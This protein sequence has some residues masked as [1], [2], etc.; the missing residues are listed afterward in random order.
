MPVVV[1]TSAGT[2]GAVLLDIL[3]VLVAAKLAAELA[4]RIKVPAVVAEIVAGVIVGP[5]VL[6]LVGQGN[7]TLAVLAEIGVILLLLEVGLEMNVREMASVGR[8]AVSV[9]VIGIVIPMA[10]GYGVAIAFGESGNTALFLGAALAATSVGIT[11]RVFSD[12]K[13]LSTVEA[14]TVLG[15]AVVDDVLG[16]VVLTVV[17]GIVTKGSISALDVLGIVGIA[18]GFLV[19]TTSLGLAFAPRLFQAIQRFAR[20]PGTL[21]ALTLSFTLAL[22]ELASAAQLAPIIGAFVAGLALSQSKVSDRI[23]RDVAPIGHIFIPVFFLQIGIAINISA[24][25]KPSVLAIAGALIVVAVLG[26]VAASIGLLGAPG[27]K[28]LVGLGMIP[29]GEVGLIFA[30]IGLAEGIL[31]ND[32]YG[33]LLLVVLGTTLLTPPLLKSRYLRVRA[34][35]KAAVVAPSPPPS[36]GWLQIRHNAVELAAEP[37][38]RLALWLALDAAAMV[39]DRQAGPKLL[40]WLGRASDDGFRWDRATVGAFM[41]LLNVGNAR[42]WRF[43]ESTGVLERALPELSAA[44][45]R[46]QSDPFMLDPSQVLEYELVDRLR[47]LTPDDATAAM[48]MDELM[49]PDRLMLAALMLDTAGTDEPVVMARQVVKRLDLGAGAEEEIALLVGQPS[50]MRA[51]AARIDGLDEDQVFRLAGA[52]D[53]PERTNALYLL[54]VVVG[55]LDPL[56]RARLDELRERVLTVLDRPE[57]TGLDARNLVE[58]RKRAALAAATETPRI[59]ARI[60]AA[61]RSYLL[62]H[63]AADVARHAV[64]LEP[65][66][67]RDE[68]RVGVDPGESGTW[69]I[70]VAARDRAGLLAMV[71][72]ALAD[73]GLDITAASVATWPDGGVLDAFI[74]HR[75]AYPMGAPTPDADTPP[76]GDALEHA[77][78]TR[79]AQVLTAPPNPDAV[80]AFDDDASPWATV[81]DIRSTDRRGLLHHLAV[82]FAVADV[83]VNSARLATS[84]GRVHDRFEVTRVG[85]E[86][87]DQATKDMVVRAVMQGVY[88]RR[89]RFGRVQKP[90]IGD[91]RRRDG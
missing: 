63:D 1:A 21:V 80:I 22:A 11:A 48:V 77:I 17:V 19:V 69:R 60:G 29:R 82:G 54:S 52:L 28:L 84:G 75:A 51:A 30:T 12:L 24:I 36:G 3:I 10:A 56:E 71:A 81:C 43:L 62:D 85:G 2:V 41:H 16:L 38:S 79:F 33:A 42:S 74:V 83:T 26:K 72:G 5:S 14:R 13:G 91:E 25:L 73:H 68:V 8:G 49:H 23:R 55:D 65:L 44:I 50:M 90:V 53:R 6:G 47:S 87:L 70:E 58:A 88:A 35:R 32:T 86:K 37:P 89:G 45:R 66:P 7:D 9:G 27:D 40:D 78:T 64:F 4:E 46:R 31:T 18:I 59:A 34:R 76:D 20:S 61:P 67:H 15:A 57:L 39:T